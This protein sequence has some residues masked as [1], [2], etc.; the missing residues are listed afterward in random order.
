M[1]FEGNNLF[2]IDGFKLCLLFASCMTL[3][4]YSTYPLVKSKELM[5]KPD[6]VS[7]H[8]ENSC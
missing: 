8:K 6:I 2:L 7:I 3:S 4:K 5:G 1:C